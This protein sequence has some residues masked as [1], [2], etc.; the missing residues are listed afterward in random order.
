MNRKNAVFKP[1]VVAEDDMQFLKEIMASNKAP[2][3]KHVTLKRIVGGY[4]TGCAGTQ[5]VCFHV[6]GATVI[7]KYCDQCIRDKK[8]TG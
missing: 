1:I 2:S 5:K 3:I 7:E 6:H 4:C 8:F